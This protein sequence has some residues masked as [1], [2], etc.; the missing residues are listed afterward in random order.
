M[1]CRQICLYLPLW[2]N[3]KKEDISPC[4][5][6]ST[7]FGELLIPLKIL[8]SKDELQFCTLLVV[9]ITTILFYSFFH[10]LCWIYRSHP[11]SK[12]ISALFLCMCYNK[13]PFIHSYCYY[14]FKGEGEARFDVN[15][16]FLLLRRRRKK[17]K[18]MQRRKQG[19]VS[20]VVVSEC[21]Y[22]YYYYIHFIQKI[23]EIKKRIRR[24]VIVSDI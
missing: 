17:N 20:C 2:R 10:I 11:L 4:H 15:I 16:I 21:C 22:Y 7:E 1:F 23:E 12:I 24:V 13:H 18:W 9:A 8:D 3:Y 19:V 14:I 6:F 5:T